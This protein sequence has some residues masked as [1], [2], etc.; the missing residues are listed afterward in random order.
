MLLYTNQGFADALQIISFKMTCT[1]CTDVVRV[2]IPSFQKVTQCLQYKTFQRDIIRVNLCLLE[3]INDCRDLRR[4][5]LKSF[6]SIGIF[7]SST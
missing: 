7:V 6:A 4:I 3:D 1:F 5:S 2:K